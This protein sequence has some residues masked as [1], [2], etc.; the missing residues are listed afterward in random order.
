[1]N[2]IPK[3]SFFKLTQLV[4]FACAQVFLRWALYHMK[5]SLYNYNEIFI[6]RGFFSR[7]SYSSRNC[8][9][10]KAKLLVANDFIEMS[11]I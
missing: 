9:M 7:Q 8:Y 1:M 2:T 3:M 10:M 11:E 4:K 6:V 5:H